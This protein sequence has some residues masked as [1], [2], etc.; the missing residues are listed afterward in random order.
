MHKRKIAIILACIILPVLFFIP[1]SIS[2]AKNTPND[3]LI[4]HFINVNHGDCT[5]I[6]FP[7][8]KTILIDSGEKDTNLAEEIISY[9]KKRGYKKIDSYM[10]TSP[11]PRSVGNSAQIVKSL[12]PSNLYIP[13]VY[14]EDRFSHFSQFLEEILELDLNKIAIDSGL[15]FSFGCEF[16]ILAPFPSLSRDSAIDELNLSSFPSDNQ[17]KNVSPF[18]YVEFMGKRI[19]LSSHAEK[20]EELKVMNKYKSGLLDDNENINLENVTLFKVGDHGSKKASLENFIK[21][22]SPE[23][24]VIS[25]GGLNLEGSPSIDTLNSLNQENSVIYRTDVSGTVKLVV[26]KDGKYKTQTQN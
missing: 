14:N 1:V 17:I 15:E 3:N 4:I 22:L 6:E 13:D 10:L 5:F 19:L 23:Y 20:S 9:V 8:G 7:N 21:F 25:V 26:Y 24:A 2:F 16:K 11:L 12:K 18:I